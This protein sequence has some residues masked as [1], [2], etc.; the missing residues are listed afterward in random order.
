[1][2]DAPPYKDQWVLVEGPGPGEAEFLGRWLLAAVAA[3]RTLHEQ[4]KRNS[5]LKDQISSLEVLY[6]IRF[7]S[8]ATRFLELLMKDLAAFTLSIK[9]D[10]I[11]LFSVMA[12]LGFFRLTGERYQMTVPGDISGTRIET[13]LLKLAATEDHYWLHP[14]YLVH[15][16]T[17]IY[18]QTW[19]SRLEKLPWMQR[20]AD[21]SILL[22]VVDL[23]SGRDGVWADRR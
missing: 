11:D 20:V 2:A 17:K 18:A 15:C 7:S 14:E 22:D 3:D 21:R 16:V 4:L 13:A 19:H 23:S 1:M 9:D 5:V 6:E 8:A 10:W 12:D